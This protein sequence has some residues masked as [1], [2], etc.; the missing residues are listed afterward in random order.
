MAER[1]LGTTFTFATTEI[2]SLSSIGEVGGDADEIDVTTLDST[3]G[4]KEF[5]QG[6]KD[7]GE[8]ALSGYLAA[9]KNQDDL[10]TAFGAGTASDCEIEF[11][12]GT[13]LTF[14]GYVKSYKVGPAEV[15]GAIGFSASIRITGAV[16]FTEAS[17]G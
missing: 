14:S 7:S 10:I 13:T 3:G 12:S 4:Y 9:G 2:G 11:P 15:N 16:T 1:A 5:L 6:F 8:V 17:A